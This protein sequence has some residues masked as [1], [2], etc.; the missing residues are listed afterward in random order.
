MNPFLLNKNTI[1]KVIL[2]FLIIVSRL[3]FISAGYG[4]EPDAW[5][6]ARAAKEIATD[7]RYHFSR[8]PGNPVQEITCSFIYKGGPIALNGASSFFGVVS[9]FFFFLIMKKY[10]ID[11][12]LIFFSCL[13]LAFLPEFYIDS[14]TSKDYLWALAF[15]LGSF[16][17]CLCKKPLIAGVLLGI[18][19]GC[20]ITSAA[21]I[22]PLSIFYLQSGTKSKRV[23]SI[24]IFVI[25]SILSGFVTF[26][27]VI[28]ESKGFGFL[29]HA[30]NKGYDIRDIFRIFSMEVWGVLGFI[31]LV[32][33]VLF[34]FINFF[35]NREKFV[36]KFGVFPK[37]HLP[38]II[39]LIIVYL[40]IF[41]RLPH[42]PAYLLPIVPFVILLVSVFSSKKFVT[43]F[44]ISIVLSSFIGFES[45]SHFK[46]NSPIISD[47]LERV[48]EMGYLNKVVSTVNKMDDAVIMAGYYLPKIDLNQANNR[49]NIYLY[50]I[51][52]KD[53]NDFQLK[54]KKIY[55][56]R[57]Q[58]EYNNYLNDY[59]LSKNGAQLIN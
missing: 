50:S 58:D 3:P 26:L 59:Y 12:D 11:D 20:R 15:I 21:M 40:L 35:S 57:Y 18:A 17:F 19:I 4:I 1:I 23:K 33:V 22:L 2:F 9:I 48:E 46:I 13:A 41:F 43:L 49:K 5:R 38:A 28:I 36:E 44:C 7:H 29:R 47:H 42:E 8:F 56:L 54:K 51:D 52:E 27:P 6:V 34:I 14:V 55:Y 24:S 10:K 37:Y 30:E 32:I 16:Y 53:F 45:I 31:S 39:I 25:I